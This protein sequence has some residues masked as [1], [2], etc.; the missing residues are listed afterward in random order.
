VD[1]LAEWRKAMV[2]GTSW[3]GG[4]RAMA[5][6]LGG[7]S[8][9]CCK[10]MAVTLLA[11]DKKYFLFPCFRTPVAPAWDDSICLRLFDGIS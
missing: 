3:I 1:N 8:S 7:S 11:V 10:G 5:L 4:S 9:S 6:T 2:V